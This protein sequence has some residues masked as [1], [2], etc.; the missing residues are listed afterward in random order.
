MLGVYA[1]TYIQNKA[2]V[3]INTLKVL[4]LLTIDL[5]GM[6]NQLK[7]LQVLNLDYTRTDV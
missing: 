4:L 2:E 6:Y 5:A 7:F 1:L 3:D